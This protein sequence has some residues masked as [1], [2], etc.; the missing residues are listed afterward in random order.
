[1][2]YTDAM[3]AKADKQFEDIV[4][5]RM[6]GI[7]FPAHTIAES[8]QCVKEMGPSDVC[9]T[10]QHSSGRFGFMNQKELKTQIKIWKVMKCICRKD[11]LKLIDL[12]GK[13]YMFIIQP[14]NLEVCGISSLAM[15][16]GLIVSGY[17]YITPHEDIALDVIKSLK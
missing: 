6:R 4:K 17:A 13:F 3:K 10:L 14:H 11:N 7:Y 1:M 8:K 15:A 9:F 12:D 2:A 5:D 16:F